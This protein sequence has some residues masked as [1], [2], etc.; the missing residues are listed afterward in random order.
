MDRQ[1]LKRVMDVAE[2]LSGMGTSVAF[3]TETVDPRPKTVGRTHDKIGA[4]TY[5]ILELEGISFC[6]GK[7]ACY[8]D[9]VDNNEKEVILKVVRDFFKY[10][11][12]TVVAHNIVFDMKVLYK[13]GID[14][15]GHK[16]YDT[17]VADHLLDERRRHGLKALA[18]ELL[19]KEVIDYKDAIAH[20]S[21]S[22]VFYKYATDDAVWTWELMQWQQP[23]LKGDL[24]LAKLF[25]EVEMPFMLSLFEMEI[26]GMYIDTDKVA[27]L[28]NNCKA[29][30]TKYIMALCEYLGV[31]YSMQT[32]L[33]SDDLTVTSPINFNSV[34]QLREIL[35]GQ[36]KLEVVETTKTGAD[37]VG[38]VTLNTYK[39][40]PFVNILY[41]YKIIEK[42]MSSY[43]GPDAQ[44]LSNLESDNRVR[45]SLK[46]T[47]TKTGRLSCSNPNVQQL[48]KP[49]K[50]YPIPIRQAFV[51]SPGYTMV[52]ADYSGQ[53]VCV[54]AEISRDETLVKALNN[55]YDM[56][57]AVA[58]KFYE[59]GMPEEALNKT[60][61]DYDMYKE[62]HDKARSQAKTITFGL[63]YGKGAYGF[64]I[65]FGITEEEAQQIVDDYF[66][67]MPGLKDAIEYAHK[68]VYDNGFVRYMSGRCRRFDT[69]TRDDWTGYTKGDLR[70]AFNAKIQGY[71]A[72]MIREASNNIYK[73]KKQY[74]HMDIKLLAMVHD[75]IILE[76]KTEHVDAAMP[77]IK[78]WMEKPFEWMCVPI[79]SDVQKGENYDQAK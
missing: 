38:K 71:S 3:D 67:G 6:D 48:S 53:E 45:T 61:P 74:E 37:G 11:C 28:Y 23:R 56:H 46:D 25:R 72:D 73:E 26:N 54:M 16:L 49:N 76:V 68:E 59:L 64:A 63:A 14:L 77:L 39:D 35:Y 43:L 57:L 65:D 78:E 2:F 27:E 50:V 15:R 21:Q 55:G 62:K 30:H 66:A 4:L 18:S 36:L 44:I 79:T 19:G 10:Q 34:K 24:Q 60:H 22:E 8:I 20:G 41:K 7:S 29:D 9:L 52:T 13:Y 47:G 75:E 12:K 1:V 40:H 42:A 70:Q 33:L 31:K 69:V 51:A 32:D 58:N 5:T 17:M